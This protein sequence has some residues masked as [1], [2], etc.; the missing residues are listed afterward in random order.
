M[1][2]Q[3]RVSKKLDIMMIK[4]HDFYYVATETLSVLQDIK[5][6]K[7]VQ[8]FIMIRLLCQELFGKSSGGS[9]PS[10]PGSNPGSAATYIMQAF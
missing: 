8:I 5:I 7:C 6:T 2:R 4:L 10:D 1:C 9:Q 3:I